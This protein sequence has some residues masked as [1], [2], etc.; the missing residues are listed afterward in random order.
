MRDNGWCREL[1]AAKW[2]TWV[3]RQMG[4]SQAQTHNA[5]KADK[6]HS[7][8][9]LPLYQERADC[10]ECCW[11]SVQCDGDIPADLRDGV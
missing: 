11:E 2:S 1:L 5:Q 10:L 9:R 7:T 4:S 6:V 3:S 8:R